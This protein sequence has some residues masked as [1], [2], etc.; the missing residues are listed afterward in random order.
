MILILIRDRDDLQQ[1]ELAASLQMGRGSLDHGGKSRMT[2]HQPKISHNVNQDAEEFLKTPEGAQMLKT[3]QVEK[4][5]Q[6]EN[7]EGSGLELQEAT[8]GKSETI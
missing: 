4:E 8:D 7:E 6:D 3:H 1:E 5:E 2:A